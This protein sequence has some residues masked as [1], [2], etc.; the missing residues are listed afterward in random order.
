[1]R[2]R[3][4]PIL[5]TGHGSLREGTREE[6]TDGP[7]DVA[8]TDQTGVPGFVPAAAS[9]RSGRVPGAPGAHLPALHLEHLP[10]EPDVRL[11][12]GGSQ[13]L[14]IHSSTTATKGSR[15]RRVV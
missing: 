10:G 7:A 11:R 2:W 6:A 14:M 4:S 8:A 13:A 5:E 15:A 1:M 3:P 9:G 12:V